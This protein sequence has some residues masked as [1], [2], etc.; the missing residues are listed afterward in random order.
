MEELVEVA[1]PACRDETVVL[2]PTGT[3]PFD[4]VSDLDAG[5]PP[6]AD[7]AVRTSCSGDHEFVVLLEEPD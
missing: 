5:L 1:C 6:E 2:T 4:T 7:S 3:R